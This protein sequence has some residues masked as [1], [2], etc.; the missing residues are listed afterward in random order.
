LADLGYIE[1]KNLVIVSRFTSG[2]EDLLPE[3]AADLVQ[4]DLDAIVALGV[5]RVRALRE[6]TDKIPIV[7]TLVADPVQSGLVN[8]LARPGGNVTGVTTALAQS[9]GKRLQLF[10]ET[11]PT[12]SRVAVLWNSGRLPLQLEEVEEAGRLLGLELHIVAVQDE[13]S[14]EATEASIAQAL[15]AALADGVD[16]VFL[17]SDNLFDSRTKEIAELI[18]ARGL[19]ASYTRADFV[20][21]GGLM[22]YGVDP[23][24]T[25]RRA[26]EYVD[27]IVRGAKPEDLPIEQPSRY[28]FRIN[29]RTAQALGISL[30]PS[31]LAQTTQLIN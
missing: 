31:V 14:K 3:L 6:A 23:Q 20:E 9:H 26:A 10:K 2:Q 21:F 28:S 25:F 13:G 16:G 4:Q 8:S 5:T 30:S 24:E 22:A 12:M 11:V 29:M 1:G 18:E 27:K 17:L 15:D 7:M 19:P